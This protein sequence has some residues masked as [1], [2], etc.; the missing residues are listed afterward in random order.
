MF[1]VTNCWLHVVCMSVW[2]R[3]AFRAALTFIQLPTKIFKFGEKSVWIRYWLGFVG[4]GLVGVGSAIFFSPFDLRHWIKCLTLVC[5]YRSFPAHR[6]R[7]RIICNHGNINRQI[8]KVKLT[9]LSHPWI[10]PS[11]SACR[12]VICGKICIALNIYRMYERNAY[13][14]PFDEREFPLRLR[15]GYEWRFNTT[16]KYQSMVY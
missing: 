8:K 1:A 2:C 10:G 12:F 9:N 5:L 13:L 7:Y 6:I 4:L 3:R 14:I 15:S 11:W 16:Y